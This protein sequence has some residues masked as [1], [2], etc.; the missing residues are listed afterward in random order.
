VC[1]CSCVC[2]F[3]YMYVC[4]C[5]CLEARA[6]L[7]LARMHPLQARSRGSCRHIQPPAPLCAWKKQIGVADSV[8]VAGV[9]RSCM[10]YCF[11]MRL[12]YRFTIPVWIYQ[13]SHSHLLCPLEFDR[14]ASF[15]GFPAV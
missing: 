14:V 2:V 11:T 9:P 13:G 6:G 15:A 3:V 1:V 12:L 4:V 8:R 5:V 10:P 7:A